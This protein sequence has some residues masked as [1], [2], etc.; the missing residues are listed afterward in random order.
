MQALPGGV[1]GAIQPM[2]EIGPEL[3]RLELSG[4]QCFNL[5]SHQFLSYGGV[6]SFARSG[7][8]SESVQIVV[9]G[10]GFRSAS[11]GPLCI[12]L[13]SRAS[14]ANSPVHPIRCR[15]LR[16]GGPSST[17]F[18]VLDWSIPVPRTTTPANASETGR[19]KKQNQHQSALTQGR[20][21]PDNAYAAALMQKAPAT[22]PF[23][24]C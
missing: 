24:R 23:P 8:R 20:V 7:E 19:R 4:D 5:N 18:P 13:H 2:D 3:G 14:G 15:H 22:G 11:N 16:A 6:A 1:P 17:G 9:C 10:C 12:L 21:E